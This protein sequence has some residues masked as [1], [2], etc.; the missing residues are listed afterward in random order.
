[1]EMAAVIRWGRSRARVIAARTAA[2]EGAWYSQ[3]QV[4]SSGTAIA[5]RNRT[6]APGWLAWPAAATWAGR[7]AAVPGA[8]RGT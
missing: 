6:W 3:K 7:G 8:S 2:A 5:P 4:S 1:M